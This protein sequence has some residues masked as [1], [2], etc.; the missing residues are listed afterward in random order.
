MRSFQK[1]L[2]IILLSIF[3]FSA[4]NEN[5]SDPQSVASNDQKSLAKQMDTEK[6]QHI[7]R[8]MKA[9][10]L[11]QGAYFIEP[12]PWGY[13]FGVTKNLTFEC[14][15][16]PDWGFVCFITGGELAFF[17]GSYGNGDFWRVNP[18]GTVS[19]KLNTNQA[20]AAYFD[21]A[22]NEYYFGTGHMNT[23][24]TGTIE[25]FC[26]EWEGETYCFTFLLEDPNAN[27]WV[28]HGNAAVTLDGAGGNSRMLQMWFSAN[29]GQQG[30][31]DIKLNP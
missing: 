26:Y 17:D 14:F 16:H 18:N 31:V 8:V 23:K 3:I 2:G 25:E 10:N 11:G 9:N 21:F 1:I 7:A 13:S 5:I 24:F 19:V 15:E 29:P 28:T 30:H 12:S 27:A 6:A 22:N 4:C 20:N